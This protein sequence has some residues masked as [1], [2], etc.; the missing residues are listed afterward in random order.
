MALQA[1]PSKKGILS[2][3]AIV[4]LM[5][6]VTALSNPIY[7]LL[8]GKG[9]GVTYT[10]SNQ[11]Y[12]GEVIIALT[13]EDERITALTAEGNSETPA[14]GQKAIAQYNETSFLELSDAY[15][16]EV[17][18]HLDAV[19]GATITSGA[20]AAGF[21]EVVEQAQAAEAASADSKTV[22]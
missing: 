12:G 1:E 21:R 6:F 11:G 3:I 8:T 2:L 20:V 5:I 22:Q 7:R 14:I 13:V 17:S 9:G 19:S 16:D 4:F 15:I 18:T 10:A